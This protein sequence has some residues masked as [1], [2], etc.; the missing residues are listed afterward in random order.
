[1]KNFIFRRFVIRR[2]SGLATLVCLV[3]CAAHCQAQLVW[4]TNGAGGSGTWDS[5]TANW[6]DGTQNVVWPSSGD[7]IFAGASGTVTS[8]FSPAPVANSIVFNT[9]GYLIQSGR[10][11][12][13][14]SGLT[15]TTNANATIS[16][17]IDNSTTTGT[18]LTKIG[19]ATLTVS[20][21]VFID[22]VNVNQGEYLVS[23]GSSLFFSDVTL[24][25]EPTAMITLGQNGTSDEMRSL[26]GG[27]N[28]GGMV[29]PDNQG[30]P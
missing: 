12:S 26:N 28:Q 29:R 25:D 21:T 11:L 22:S 10:L 7:A 15:V 13:G 14:P 3:F 16:S 1:M 24:A 4:G 8:G 23:A 20:G 17:L 30:A 9:P 19:P 5:V 18:F 6:F 2:A 27:G